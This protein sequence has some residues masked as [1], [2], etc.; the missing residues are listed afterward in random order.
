MKELGRFNIFK[1]I[2][3]LPQRRAIG[4]QVKQAWEGYEAKGA[5][6]AGVE[7]GWRFHGAEKMG[8]DIFDQVSTQVEL[9]LFDEEV[10]QGLEVPP[11]EDVLGEFPVRIVK[12]D[13]LMKELDRQCGGLP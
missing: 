11:A 9:E 10:K 13:D 2:L 7:L 1:A 12:V 4:K 6:N 5:S 8:R 3:E